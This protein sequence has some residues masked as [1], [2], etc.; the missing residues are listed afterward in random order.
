MMKIECENLEDINET[1]G[2]LI[3]SFFIQMSLNPIEFTTAGFYTLNLPFL[4]SV[5]NFCFPN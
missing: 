2:D 1:C 3:R 4:A 5:R